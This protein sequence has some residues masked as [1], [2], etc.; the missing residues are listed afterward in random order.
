MVDYMI[1]TSPSWT[2][3]Y[4]YYGT[5]EAVKRQCDHVLLWSLLLLKKRFGVCDLED[6]SISWRSTMATVQRLALLTV[7][8]PRKV[9]ARQMLWSLQFCLL[10]VSQQLSLVILK[11]GLKGH[12]GWIC[13]K[14]RLLYRTYSIN[15]CSQ[16]AVQPCQ[17][18]QLAKL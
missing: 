4:R 13:P 6:S 3:L 16:Q 15:H 11:S 10:P 1:D 14:P 12:L 17:S 5:M 8:L 9:L 7:G 18:L 2:W